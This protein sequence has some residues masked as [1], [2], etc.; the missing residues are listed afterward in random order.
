MQKIVGMM[1]QMRL[2]YR[3]KRLEKSEMRW[4]MRLHSKVASEFLGEWK[5]EPCGL[6]NVRAHAYTKIG[7]LDEFDEI[8][9]RKD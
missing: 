8:K 6:R 2:G 9:L 3:E 1:I 5:G 4:K 7:Y